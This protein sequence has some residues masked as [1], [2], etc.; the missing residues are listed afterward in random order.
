MHPIYLSI[1]YLTSTI[2]KIPRQYEYP[3]CV[4]KM[5]Y[6]CLTFIWNHS[7]QYSV[8]QRGRAPEDFLTRTSFSYL[9]QL[10]Y[11]NTNTEKILVWQNSKPSSTRYCP[12]IRLLF[13]KESSDLKNMTP[14][15]MNDLDK[16]SE[17]YVDVCQHFHFG[18][19]TRHVEIHCLDTLLHVNYRLKEKIWQMKKEENNRAESRNTR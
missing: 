12:P 1:F 19:S 2:T 14:K 9:L 13:Q 5:L 7:L 3:R 15:M 17:K 10:C 11:I 18:L 4:E 8:K 6:T 16:V